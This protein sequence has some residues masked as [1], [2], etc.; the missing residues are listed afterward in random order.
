MKLIIDNIV[1]RR[2]GFDLA[3]SAQSHERV[4]GIVGPSGAGK[5]TLLDVLA[6]I[7]RPE[8]GRVTLDGAILTDVPARIHLPT[9]ARRVGYV[10]QDLALFPHLNVRRN[11]LYGRK[12]DS[13]SLPLFE[14]EHVMRVLEIAGVA[15]RHVDDLSGGEKQRV[16]LARALLSSPGV[17]LLDE[18]L[19]NLDRELKAQ[20]VT[21][22][23]RVR[24][25]FHMPMLLV[26]HSVEDIEQLC[27]AAITLERGRVARYEPARPTA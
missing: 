24:D 21:Y 4:T 25:E 22:L 13:A 8:Q 15:D 6:G 9:R 1:V 16:A 27:D 7:I 20:I 2:P 23:K 5:T 26:S 14:F 3:V 10:P 18:P 17:L 19:S 12:P 11:L